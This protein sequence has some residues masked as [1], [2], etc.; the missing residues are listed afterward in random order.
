[1]NDLRVAF[2]VFGIVLEWLLRWKPACI[3]PRHADTLGRLSRM[4]KDAIKTKQ[5]ENDQ[6]PPVG[7]DGY[8]SAD[9]ETDGPIPGPFSLLSFALVYAGYFDGATFR[10]P[11]SYKQSLYLEL[12]PISDNFQE[13][14]LRVNGLDRARLCVE[15]LAPEIAMAEAG[16]YIY[17]SVAPFIRKLSSNR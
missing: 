2:M 11:S 9:V 4:L 13:E 12:K 1:V 7:A 5:L 10:R 14:A 6:A 17:R 16:A 3:A 8:F 15:G